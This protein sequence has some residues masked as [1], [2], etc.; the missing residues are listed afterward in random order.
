LAADNDKEGKTVEEI[1]RE[2]EGSAVE[3]RKGHSNAV[4]LLV[5]VVLVAAA[6]CWLVS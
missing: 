5:A 1:L 3:K 2:V 6:I 4:S